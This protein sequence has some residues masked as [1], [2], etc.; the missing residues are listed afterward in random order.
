[1]YVPD[2]GGVL[3]GLELWPRRAGQRP[4]YF[5]HSNIATPFFCGGVSRNRWVWAGVGVGVGRLG[6]DGRVMHF[7]GYCCGCRYGWGGQ[8]WKGGSWLLVC[9]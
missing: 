6:M 3:S 4:G 8:D 5:C 7:G 1:M 9:T 2:I